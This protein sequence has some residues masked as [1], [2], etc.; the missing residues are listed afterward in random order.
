MSLIKGN[1]GFGSFFLLKRSQGNW[2]FATNTNFLIP[3]YLLPDGG[4]H[5]YFKLR[6]FNLPKLIV[7][8]KFL[9]STTL[10]CKDRKQK[11]RVCGKDLISLDFKLWSF[12]PYTFWSNAYIICYRENHN[13]RILFHSMTLLILF[14][15]ANCRKDKMLSK[16]GNMIMFLQQIDKGIESLP[17]TLIFQPLYLCNPIS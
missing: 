14:F 10:G 17:Q 12:F 13:I 9:R 2:V 8:L 3:I 15:G 16:N 4:T 1:L 6:L 11:I 7:L 5:W